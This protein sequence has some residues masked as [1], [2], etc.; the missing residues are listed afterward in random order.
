[1]TSLSWIRRT[2]NIKAINGDEIIF[3]KNFSFYFGNKKKGKY[4]MS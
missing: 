2:N 4:K 3:R 1:M